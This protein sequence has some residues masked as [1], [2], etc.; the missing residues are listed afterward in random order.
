LDRLRHLRPPQTRAR[1]TPA[2]ANAEHLLKQT[3]RF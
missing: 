1:R 3:R 2:A